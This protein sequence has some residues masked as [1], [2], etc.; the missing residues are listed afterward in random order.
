MGNKEKKF[1]L[2]S[3]GIVPLGI[4]CWTI[5]SNIPNVA[6]SWAVKTDGFIKLALMIPMLVYIVIF[7]VGMFTAFIVVAD[8]LRFIFG[9]KENDSATVV[10][11]I[12]NN[13]AQTPL[14]SQTSL[15]ATNKSSDPIS[16][17]DAQQSINA[18]LISASELS[19][20]DSG[21][22]VGEE[23]DRAFTPR[24]VHWDAVEKARK[25]TG[26]IGEAIVVEYEK[27]ALSRNLSRKEKKKLSDKVVLVSEQNRGYDVL[28]Q[29]EDGRDKYIEVK[30]FVGGEAKNF[31][32]TRNELRFLQSHTDS[33]FIYLV[34]SCDT[35]PKITMIPGE[36]F[37][38]LHLKPSAF[39]I[40][41]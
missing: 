8:L 16:N 38:K 36:R 11:R 9:S 20:N 18:D 15:A 22:I 40:T 26:D 10:T 33:T 32:V 24:K 23:K 28:S 3:W 1:Y 17:I 7:T 39:K 13:S 19:I 2:T 31:T 37:L 35:E 27:F 21:K 5:F 6:F 30:S 29:F 34:T 14:T 4:F 12:R 25:R 41:L